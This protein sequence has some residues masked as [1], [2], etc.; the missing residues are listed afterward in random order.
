MHRTYMKLKTSLDSIVYEYFVSL[1]LCCT[2]MILGKKVNINKMCFKFLG[3][4]VLFGMC[5]FPGF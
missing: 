4:K 3:I 2:D 1:E 5:P